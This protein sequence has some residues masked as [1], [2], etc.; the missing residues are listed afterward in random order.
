MWIN[1]T[2]TFSSRRPGKKP[3]PTTPITTQL[4]QTNVEEH[5]PLENK[6]P[7]TVLHLKEEHIRPGTSFDNNLHSS[8]KATKTQVPFEVTLKTLKQDVHL[9]LLKPVLREQPWLEIQKIRNARLS[10]LVALP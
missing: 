4:W 2:N 6:C 5:F 3:S 10:S 8:A 1:Y 9:T 7:S